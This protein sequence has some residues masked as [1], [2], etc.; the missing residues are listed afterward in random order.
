MLRGC[1][2]KKLLHYVAAFNEEL[3]DAAGS[4]YIIYSDIMLLTNCYW[5]KWR[6]IDESLREAEIR[7]SQFV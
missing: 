7:M 5:R 6:C 2:P 1:V 3:E 4:G